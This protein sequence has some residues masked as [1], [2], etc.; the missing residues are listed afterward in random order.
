MSN[1]VNKISKSVKPSC[2]FCQRICQP[3]PLYAAPPSLFYFFIFWWWKK[4][5]MSIVAS[6]ISISK[7]R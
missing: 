7:D 1:A 2:P 5:Y 6:Q 3:L 4:A